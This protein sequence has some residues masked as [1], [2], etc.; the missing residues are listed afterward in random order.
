MSKILSNPDYKAQKALRMHDVFKRNYVINPKSLVT[1]AA[2]AVKTDH[3]LN[4]FKEIYRRCLGIPGRKTY[5]KIVPALCERGEWRLALEWHKFLVSNGDT[6]LGPTPIKELHLVRPDLAAYYDKF[7]PMPSTYQAKTITIEDKAS[8]PALEDSAHGFLDVKLPPATANIDPLSDH[9]CARLFATRSFS[10]RFIIAGLK[11]FES[12]RLGPLALRELF[13]RAESSEDAVSFINMLREAD[14]S[15]TTTSYTRVIKNFAMT[16]RFDELQS[17]VQSDL[18]PDTLDDVQLQSRL[19]NMYQDQGDRLG[20]QRTAAIIELISDSIEADTAQSSRLY[21]PHQRMTRLRQLKRLS[22]VLEDKIA[23]GTVEISDFELVFRR[24]LRPRLPGRKPAREHLFEHDLSIL[25]NIC[26]LALRSGINVPHQL[27]IEVLKRYGMTGKFISV[28]RFSSILVRTLARQIESVAV[29][30]MESSLYRQSNLSRSLSQLPG[31][32]PMNYMGQVLNPRTIE[33]IIVWGFK[34]GINFVIESKGRLNNKALGPSEFFLGLKV[35]QTLAKHGLDIHISSISEILR[36]RLRL[37]SVIHNAPRR[38]HNIIAQEFNRFS[39]EELL[40]AIGKIW[41]GSPLFPELFEISE[42]DAANPVK[43][44]EPLFVN[45]AMVPPLLEGLLDITSRRDAKPLEYAERIAKRLQLRLAIFG[46]M[47]WSAKDISSRESF[48]Q[49]MQQNAIQADAALI[50]RGKYGRDLPLVG[51]SKGLLLS[52]TE[53]LVTHIPKTDAAM[54]QRWMYPP[55]GEG[56][57]TPQDVSDMLPGL[58]SF[59]KERR[60]VKQPVLS[61]S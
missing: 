1:L 40:F 37:L 50:R 49:S 4:T 53:G 2:S 35:V 51:T 28:M 11:L 56:Q 34:I 36:R 44:R 14:I 45:G 21:T 38:R 29:R 60:D 43:K 52:K 30:R 3:G 48:Y 16:G 5:D 26:V 33:A 10:I 18:H 39:L 15:I 13:L 7:Q 27:W 54:I 20:V 12:R 61:F 55:P 17:L 19:L 57:N 25:S 47:Y 9:I 59:A 23:Q 6:P 24:I 8:S 58:L 42:N 31:Q 32:H 41:T 46:R 22:I